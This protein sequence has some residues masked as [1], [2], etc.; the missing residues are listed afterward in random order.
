[1]AL[2]DDVARTAFAAAALRGHAQFK[3]D[4]IKTHASAGMAGDVS[5][6]DTAADTNNHGS[7]ARGGGW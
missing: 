5:V 1:M 3:L 6:G 2:G 4:F 7:Q